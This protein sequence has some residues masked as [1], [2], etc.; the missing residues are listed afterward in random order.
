MTIQD[1]VC[2]RLTLTA[3]E[4]CW[5]GRLDARPRR[6]F[7]LAGR[8]DTKAEAR[9]PTYA[10][11]RRTA[12]PDRGLP[13][14]HRRDRPLFDRHRRADQQARDRH[15]SMTNGGKQVQRCAVTWASTTSPT[16]RRFAT[17]P[18]STAGRSA[19]FRAEFMPMLA[20]K[21]P[22]N[23]KI[24][25]KSQPVPLAGVQAPLQKFNVRLLREIVRLDGREGRNT[26]SRSSPR[27]ARRG[28]TTRSATSSKPGSR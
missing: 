2:R 3:I 18:T 14:R 6:I 11:S 25:D 23:V 1:A 21:G 13:A 4:S 17:R 19:I 27:T 22:L 16:S 28:S 5:R 26:R 10:P 12:S 15:V 24:G 20:G 8:H 9:H 7:R